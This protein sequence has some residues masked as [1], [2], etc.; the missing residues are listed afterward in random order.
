MLKSI[1]MFLSLLILIGC[2]GAD[3]NESKKEVE[4]IHFDTITIRADFKKETILK[5]RWSEKRTPDVIVCD[6]LLTVNETNRALDFWRRLGYKFGQV[7]I[8]E[9]YGDC[10]HSETSIGTIRIS[11]PSSDHYHLLHDRLAV[12][13]TTKFRYTGEIISVEI[14]IH[15]Y[16]I[17]KKLTL[18]HEIGHA[19]GWDHMRVEGHIMHPEWKHL[20]PNAEGVDINNYRQKSVKVSR[21]K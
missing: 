21:P 6:N 16:A 1:F 20:G 19:L 3:N 13:H 8:G 10:M 2:K 12:T 7:R 4:K 5:S 14:I 11:L 15:E 17:N 18:E 9:Q